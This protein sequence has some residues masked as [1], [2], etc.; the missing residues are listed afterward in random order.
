MIGEL[1]GLLDKYW[2]WLRDET[3]LQRIAEWVQISTPYLDRHNDYLAIYVKSQD[4]R[5]LLTDDGYV[6]E[7]LE[8][9]GC[10]LN[11]PKRRILFD[12]TL[13]GFGI[14][15]NEQ[16]KALEVWASREE[17][18]LKKHNLVQA[19]LAVNDLFYLATPT[20]SSLFLE[21]VTNWLNI[22]NIRYTPDLKLTGRSGYDHRFEFVIPMSSQQ[23]ERIIRA[24]NRPTRDTA[25]AIVFSWMDT[26]DTRAS[27]SRA[28]A[29]LNDSVQSVAGAVIDAM[30]SY[31]VWPIVWSR[32]EEA[33]AELAA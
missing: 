28:Y 17:F 16:T 26:R 7:D 1:Q 18:A 9:S 11:S 20:I 33:V 10:R 3:G 27:E 31:D 13:R 6:V 15:A 21:D 12:T 30:H 8:Q 2:E 4:D 29:I 23:P 32:R 5:Y 14:R 24:I 25:E 19:M 22:N